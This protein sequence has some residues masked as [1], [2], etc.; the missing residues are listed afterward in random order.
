MR[1]EEN[2]R[3]G[4]ARARAHSYIGKILGLR[5]SVRVT[6]RV[7][8]RVRA[9]YMICFVFLCISFP[10]FPPPPGNVRLYDS[11]NSKLSTIYQTGFVFLIRVVCFLFEFAITR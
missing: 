10:S 7:I 6:V 11:G 2:R 1:Q 4:N 3:G 5:A 9:A 8:V